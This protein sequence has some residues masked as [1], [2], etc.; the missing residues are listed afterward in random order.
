MG[1]KLTVKIK[2]VKEGAIVPSYAHP[3]DAGMDLYASERI[4]A[5]TNRVTTVPTGIAMEIPE[6][7]VGFIWDKS[8]L[9]LK[10][11]IKTMAGVIDSGYR[12]EVKVI[13][14]NLGDED[15]VFEKGNKVAQMIIQRKPLVEVVKVDNLSDT[16]RGE[17]G[18]GS[19]G[20]K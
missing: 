14:I 20:K 13:V 18:F 8:G 4:V 12:G 10:N 16:E 11:G 19:T 1:E 3:G 5:Y 17:G 7:H 9:A 6:E 2:I 15:V